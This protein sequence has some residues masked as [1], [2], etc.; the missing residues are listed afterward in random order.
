MI[1]LTPLVDRVL[2]TTR[3]LT[4]RMPARAG[5]AVGVVALVAAVIVFSSSNA[6][7]E[8]NWPRSAADRVA[9]LSSQPGNGHVFADETYADWLLFVRPELRSRIAYDARFELLHPGEFRTLSDY[10]KKR[11][12]RWSRAANGYNVFVYDT[13]SGHCGGTCT[14]VYR[15][16]YVTVATRAR[17]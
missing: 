3:T 6:S 11:G 1:V 9:L 7:L 14:A 5:L 15:D 4:G 12:N 17:S 10:G 16:R 13:G 8:R 2:G